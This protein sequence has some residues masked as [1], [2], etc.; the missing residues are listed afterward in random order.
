M[1]AR[2]IRQLAHVCIFARSLEETAAFYA[3][4]LGIERKFS[5]MREGREIGF[6]L[7]TGGTTHIEVFANTAAGRAEIN[8]IDHLCLEVVNMDAAIARIRGQGVD[9]SD[10]KMGCDETWQTWLSDPNG[11]RIELFEYT[12]TS[13][14][15]C[16]GD[17]VAN[18]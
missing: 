13:A 11:V 1:S 12:G 6:Y 14:Q 8:Q 9:V 7:E 3:G 17:R 5:F 15:F 2:I 10:K 16:G 4:A 18:W